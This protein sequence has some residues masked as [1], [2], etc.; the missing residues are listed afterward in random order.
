MG[1]TGPLER[2]AAIIPWVQEVTT[3]KLKQQENVE[4]EKQSP[5]LQK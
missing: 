4:D 1:E 2:T 5:G 3:D